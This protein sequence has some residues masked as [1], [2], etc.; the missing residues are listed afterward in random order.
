M[1]LLKLEEK[2]KIA[3][4]KRTKRVFISYAIEDYEIAKKLYD[5]LKN[6]GMY[7]WIAPIDIYAG[8]NW[9][10][11]IGLKIEESDYFLTLLFST[12]VSKR[13]YVQYELEIALDVL[14]LFPKGRI[15]IIPVRIDD[16]AAPEELKQQ[17]HYADLFPSYEDDLSKILKSLNS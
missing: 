17:I 11:E 3:I 10:R 7:P 15:F 1:I 5:D 2:M 8:Q 6:L 14:K 9:R 4:S 16:C 13:G 12:S